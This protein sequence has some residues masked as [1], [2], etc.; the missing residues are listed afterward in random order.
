MSMPW[1]LQFINEIIHELPEDLNA[2]II[3]SEE[4]EVAVMELDEQWSYVGNKK[5][6]E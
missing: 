4:Q 2:K 1:L 3:C 5:N 6:Q